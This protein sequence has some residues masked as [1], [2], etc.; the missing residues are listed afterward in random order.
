MAAVAALRLNEKTF[1][2][3]F[4]ALKDPRSRD[5]ILTKEMKAS[6]E[7]VFGSFA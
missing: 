2:K 1:S 6:G 4:A 5:Y 7:I 3:T